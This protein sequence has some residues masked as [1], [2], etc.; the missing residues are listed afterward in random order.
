M[1]ICRITRNDAENRIKAMETNGWK[2][3]PAS[4]ALSADDY[5][6]SDDT[7][8]LDIERFAKDQIAKFLTANYSGHAMAELVEATAV[9][10]TFFK[11]L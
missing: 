5:E 4:T 1:T 8:E 11:I 3:K 6:E 7:G 9:R 10:L 2:S